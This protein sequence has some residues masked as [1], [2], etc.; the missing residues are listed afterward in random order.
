MHRPQAQ[1]Q[2]SE[3]IYLTLSE[4]F[5]LSW[6]DLMTLDLVSVAQTLAPLVWKGLTLVPDPPEFERGSHLAENCAFAMFA[7]ADC[8]E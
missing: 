2:M 6:W 7:L 1:L 5:F 8:V 3:W 4:L